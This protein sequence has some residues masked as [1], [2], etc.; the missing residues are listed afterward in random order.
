MA[1]NCARHMMLEGWTH[2]D[3]IIYI[4]DYC[5]TTPERGLVFKLHGNW[6]RISTNDKF[7]VTVKTDFDCAKCLDKKEVQQ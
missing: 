6:H 7:E 2:Y 5:M 3:T 4:M 1:C